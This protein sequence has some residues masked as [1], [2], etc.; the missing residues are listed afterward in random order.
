MERFAV[1]TYRHALF[2]DFLRFL[3]HELTLP[4]LLIYMAGSYLSDKTS[5]ND[6]EITLVADQSFIQS[7]AAQ[8]IIPLGTA[9]EHHRLKTQYRVDF[10]ITIELAGYN[11]FRTFFQY[12]GDKT[13]QDKGIDAKDK[14]GIIRVIYDNLG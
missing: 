9:S 7:S 4:E 11:D 14:R 12:E 3:R 2:N 6:I 10:Y 13:A 5:P 1:S 8:K